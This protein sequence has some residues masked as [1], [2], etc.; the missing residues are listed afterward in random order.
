MYQNYIFD[1]YGTL[2]D[3]NTNEGK[4]YLWKK[5]VRTVSVTKE[6]TVEQEGPAPEFPDEPV[7]IRPPKLFRPVAAL[8]K[9]LGI[10]ILFVVF[11]SFLFF[12]A[13]RNIN[14]IAARVNATDSIYGSDIK[15]LKKE[16]DEVWRSL[17]STLSGQMFR[18]Q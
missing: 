1:L 18:K 17:R 12:I 7:R 9:G 10:A 15:D 16:M 3:I 4:P 13:G 11:G 14:Q 8:F 6:N 2:V 5:T